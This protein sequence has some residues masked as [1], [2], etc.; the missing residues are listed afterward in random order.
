MWYVEVKWFR[1]LKERE[2]NQG[3]VCGSEVSQGIER[4]VGVVTINRGDIESPL[5]AL[6][7]PGLGG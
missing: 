2:V 6:V 7:W 4:A 1:A 3:V 5:D